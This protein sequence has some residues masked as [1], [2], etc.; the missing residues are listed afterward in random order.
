MKKIDLTQDIPELSGL[1]EI[2]MRIEQMESLLAIAHEAKDKIASTVL[3]KLVDYEQ[4]NKVWLGDNIALAYQK[5]NYLIQGL[6]D[7]E[8]QSVNV[9]LIEHILVLENKQSKGAEG[10]KERSL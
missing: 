6:N 3:Q 9:S 8:N 4:A 1:I 10:E 5:I 2:S 7:D